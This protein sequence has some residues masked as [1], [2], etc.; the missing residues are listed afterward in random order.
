M[1]NQHI[2]IALQTDPWSS[3]ILRFRV[4]EAVV[5][6]NAYIQIQRRRG[7]SFIRVVSIHN[8]ALALRVRRRS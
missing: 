8:V 7:E 5:R 2:Y 4:A 6:I 1:L 3:N